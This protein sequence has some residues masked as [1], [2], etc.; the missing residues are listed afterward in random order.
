MNALLS[1]CLFQKII[2]GG[3]FRAE[4]AT[5]T[6]KDFAIQ[7]KTLSMIKKDVEDDENKI[8]SARDEPSPLLL[9]SNELLVNVKESALIPPEEDTPKQGN[10]TQVVPVIENRLEDN[11]EEGR[12]SVAMTERRFNGSTIVKTWNSFVK[13]KCKVRI[14]SN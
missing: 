2:H 9:A 14:S 12:L 3:M 7:T 1:T 10:L 4:S 13:A 8:A 6:L 5:S 11:A